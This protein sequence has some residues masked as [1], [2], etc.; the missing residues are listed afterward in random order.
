MRLSLSLLAQDGHARATRVVLPRGAFETP[1]FMPVGTQGTVKAMHPVEL[2][3]LGAQVILCNSYHLYLRP[4]APLVAKLGG[5]HAF[6]GWPGLILTDSG[7]FQVFSLRDLARIDDQGVTFRSHLDGSSHALS[8]ESMMEVQAAL[9]PDIAMAFDQCPPSQA[10]RAAVEEALERTTRWAERCV[11][12]PRPAHQV[13]F[14]IVQGGLH[15]D[16]RRRHLEEIG[17]LPFEGIALGGLSV[18]ERPEEMHRVLSE[19]V[20]AM[21]VDRPRYLMGVGRP[22]DL[23]MAIGAGVDMFDCV[24]PTRNARNGQLFTREGRIVISNARFRDDP[25][26]PDETCACGTCRTFSR[27]YLRHLF[28]AKEILYSR[29]ATAHNLHQVL[30]LV[31]EARDAIRQGRFAAFSRDFFARRGQEEADGSAA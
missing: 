21:P 1:V 3:A 30:R 25:R 2:E 10:P 11:G 4:G 22:E 12:Q 31:A 17:A 13:R 16:L 9:G 5:L 27:A 7:G 26:P 14:G 23:V 20:P 6:T 18:G 15:L 8:P 24:M 28:V 29:L 19:I